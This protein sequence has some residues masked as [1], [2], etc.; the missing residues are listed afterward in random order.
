MSY[1][2]NSFILNTVVFIGI[3]TLIALGYG[4]VAD[5]MFLVVLGVLLAFT[6]GLVNAHLREWL[7]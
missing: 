5:N 1:R 6:L 3:F 7:K 4:G 2:I